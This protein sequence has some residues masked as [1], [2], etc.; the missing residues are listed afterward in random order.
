MDY[1]LGV[2]TDK[3]LTPWWRNVADM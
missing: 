3:G 1:I 2:F